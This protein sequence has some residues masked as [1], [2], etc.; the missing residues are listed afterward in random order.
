MIKNDLIQLISLSKKF[1]KTKALDNVSFSIPENSVLGLLGPN[2]SGKSTLM[3]IIAGLIRNWDGDLIFQKQSIKENHNH[4]LGQCGFLIENPTFY[5][6][7]TAHQNLSILSRISNC[8]SYKINEVL[9]DV[10]LIDAAHKKIS[11]FSYGMKQRL[12]IAQAILHDPDILF[13]DEPNNGLDP[14]GIR[15]MNKTISNLHNKGKTIVISTHILHDVEELCSNIVILKEG[16]VLLNNSMDELIE[17]S[18]TITIKTKNIELLH[19]YLKPEV[20]CKIIKSHRDQITIQTDLDVC[21]FS[22]LLPN[23]INLKSIIKEP[24]LSEFFKL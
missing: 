21:S 12:G 19:E 16:R 11:D 15:E 8:E 22:K 9:L 5:Q 23:D 17:K 14:L 3:R 2:G 1:G 10:D 13:L 4:F 24:D 7:L 6:N 18:K 20:R